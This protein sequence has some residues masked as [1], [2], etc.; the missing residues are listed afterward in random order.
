ML[1]NGAPPAPELSSELG[2][3]DQK[4]HRSTEGVVDLSWETEN[5]VRFELEEAGPDEPKAFALRYAGPDASTV[6]TG[7]S[8]GVHHF[9]VRAFDAD[10]DPGPWSE[11]LAVEVA[12]MPQGKV[13]LLLLLGG[14][15]VIATISTILHGHFTHRRSPQS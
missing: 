10:G 4:V 5:A 6:R 8:E 11:E 1:A 15:V 13:R 2:A 9:R 7:L 14:V 3:D 12:Y